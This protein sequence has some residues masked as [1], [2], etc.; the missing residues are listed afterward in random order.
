[1]NKR[2]K[3]DEV[4]LKKLGMRIKSIRKEKGITQVA[5]AYACEIEKQNMSRIE[6]GN[7]NPNILLLRKICAHLEIPLNELFNF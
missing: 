7:T 1:M 3:S 6:A 5:L 2:S 4:Y